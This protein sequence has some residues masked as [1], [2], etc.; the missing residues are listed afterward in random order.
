MPYQISFQ[1]N[2]ANLFLADN[3]QHNLIVTVF[4]MTDVWIEA[5]FSMINAIDDPFYKFV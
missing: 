3:S 2:Y 4:A 1:N 5:I